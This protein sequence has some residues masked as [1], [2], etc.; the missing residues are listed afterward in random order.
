MGRDP[1]RVGKLTGGQSA[2]IEKRREHGG[3]R[4]LPDQRRYLGDERAYNHF[5]YIAPDR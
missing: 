5:P 4:R 2:A 3:S 1:G